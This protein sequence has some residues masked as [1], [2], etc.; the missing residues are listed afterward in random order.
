MNE[1]TLACG[2]TKFTAF[3]PAYVT[4]SLEN[5]CDRFLLSVMVDGSPRC[6][7]DHEHSAPQSRLYSKITCN[8]SMT[9]RTWRLNRFS[10]EANRADNA[11]GR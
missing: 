5:I 10:V 1:V 4:F 8:S 11:N 6:W 7:V 9:L 3:A 2:R